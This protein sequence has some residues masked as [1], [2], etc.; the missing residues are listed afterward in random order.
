M[1]YVILLHGLARTPRSMWLME[2]K[3]QREG[4]QVVNIGYPSR[5]KNVRT[6]ALQTIPAALSRCENAKTIHVVT[7]SLGGILLRYYMEDNNIANL[8]RVVMLSPPNQGSELVDQL[9]Q[10][11]WFELFNGSAGMQL[12]TDTESIPRQLGKPDFPLGIISGTISLNPIFSYFLP[13]PN[14]GKVSIESAKIAGMV[15]FLAVPNSHSFIMNDRQVI[16]Q[17]LFFL[18]HGQFEH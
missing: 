9:S 3:L 15:D 16:A 14:D 18:A 6:L 12:G 13:S 1:E 10:Y 8:G 5:K 2:K 17:I 11:W 7:H 4:Y